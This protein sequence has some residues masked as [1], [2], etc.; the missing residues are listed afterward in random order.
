VPAAGSKVP[1]AG[2]SGLSPKDFSELIA[3]NQ[4][5]VQAEA[6]KNGQ[7]DHSIKPSKVK[8]FD[9][10]FFICSKSKAPNWGSY[11]WNTTIPV[12]WSSFAGQLV[13]RDSANAQ[14]APGTVALHLVQLQNR[15]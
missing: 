5:F 7:P 14:I 15:L 13:V 11:F 3:Q 6:A 8:A 1:K 10:T 4:L 12:E 2:R 9:L